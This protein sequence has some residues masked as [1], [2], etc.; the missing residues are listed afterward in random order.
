MAPLK[1]LLV[2]VSS[3]H[4]HAQLTNLVYETLAQILQ[5][6]GIANFLEV[7]DFLACTGSSLYDRSCHYNGLLWI[8]LLRSWWHVHPPTISGC[9]NFWKSI[10]WNLVSNIQLPNDNSNQEQAANMSFLELGFFESYF[11]P[12]SKTLVTNSK[13]A[14]ADGRPVEGKTL[15]NLEHQVRKMISFFNLLTWYTDLEFVPTVL[16]SPYRPCHRLWKVG[17][18]HLPRSRQQSQ[19]ETLPLWWYRQFSKQEQGMKR[20]VGVCYWFPF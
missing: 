3:L 12:M 1:E 5:I 10:W 13:Q 2:D 6:I 16:Y 7:C 11:I 4:A 9:F 18:A 17:S 14:K 19:V 8:T 15:S 20:G